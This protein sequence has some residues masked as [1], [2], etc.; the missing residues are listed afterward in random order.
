MGFFM[1]IN[2]DASV[3]LDG[4]LWTTREVNPKMVAQLD[5]FTSLIKQISTIEA[6]SPLRERCIQSLQGLERSAN[7]PPETWEPVKQVASK[8]LNV[9]PS[10]SEK[11]PSEE[12]LGSFYDEALISGILHILGGFT[13]KA[14][15]FSKDL[16][17]PIAQVVIPNRALDEIACYDYALLALGDLQLQGDYS[18]LPHSLIERGYRQVAR[19][20]SGD[21]VLYRDQGAP[22]HLGVV[23]ENGLVESKYGL[24]PIIFF[25]TVENALPMYGTEIGYFRPPSP[26]EMERRNLSILEN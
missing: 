17:A 5:L 13:Q 8:V 25:H 3:D 7:V 6:S 21:L 4:A 1:S 18:V 11:L 16:L 20:E 14:I 2:I 15:P 23:R 9:A 19:A 12:E 10:F 26:E 24:F 22:T